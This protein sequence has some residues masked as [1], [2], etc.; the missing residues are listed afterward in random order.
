MLTDFYITSNLLLSQYSKLLSSD[1]LKF[2]ISIFLL[3]CAVSLRKMSIISKY[4]YL[5]FFKN[6]HTLKTLH[7][8]EHLKLWFKW[9]VLVDC[10]G[11]VTF[12]GSFYSADVRM[13]PSNVACA[14]QTCLDKSL[15]NTSNL[16]RFRLQTPLHVFWG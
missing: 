5:P 10:L 7:T 4:L 8:F 12:L 1:F 6:T 13:F 14:A 9:T 15:Q 3:S 16:I 2:R 11:L